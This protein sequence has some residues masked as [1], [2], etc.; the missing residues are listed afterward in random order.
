[1]VTFT[2]PRQGGT[3]KDDIALEVIGHNRSCYCVH[4]T[5][6]ERVTNVRL[7]R[8]RIKGQGQPSAKVPLNRR[9]RLISELQWQHHYAQRDRPII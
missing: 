6:M 7:L 4:P 9:H 1:M 2:G 8:L 5:A 3:A